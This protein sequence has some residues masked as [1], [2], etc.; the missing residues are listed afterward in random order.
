MNQRTLLELLSLLVGALPAMTDHEYKRWLQATIL[1][2]ELRA[3]VKSKR[4]NLSA[5]TLLRPIK[6]RSKS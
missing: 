4:P 3:D 6:R 2:D 1:M 5:N